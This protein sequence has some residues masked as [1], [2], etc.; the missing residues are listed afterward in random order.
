MR[1]KGFPNYHFEGYDLDRDRFEAIRKRVAKLALRPPE[2]EEQHFK[3]L[4]NAYLMG[5]KDALNIIGEDYEIC[6][7][8]K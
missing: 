4:V 5:I 2:T 6:R 7:R 1:Q 3:T 8:P